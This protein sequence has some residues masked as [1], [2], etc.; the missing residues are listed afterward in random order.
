MTFLLRFKP[1]A[2]EYPSTVSQRLEALLWHPHS[3][4]WRQYR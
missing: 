3:S 1:S 2:S 4:H